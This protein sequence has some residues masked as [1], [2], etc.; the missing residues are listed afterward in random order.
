LVPHCGL[1]VSVAGAFSEP[2]L[3]A[4]EFGVV[5]IALVLRKIPNPIRLALHTTR[6]ATSILG[7]TLLV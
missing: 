5:C 4:L 3:K 2:V 1:A 7:M 6:A